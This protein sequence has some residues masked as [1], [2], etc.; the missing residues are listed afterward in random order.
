MDWI[1]YHH[2]YYFWIIATEGGVTAASKKIRLSQSTLSAQLKQ[3]EDSLG[4]PLFDRKYR[5]LV[6]TES[7]RLALD[8]ASN[9]FKMGQEMHDLIRNRLV[10][11]KKQIVRIGALSSLSKNLQFDFISPCIDDPDIRVIV[12]E[13][14]L[15]ELTAKLE[16]FELDLVISNMPVRSDEKNHIYNHRL[17]SIPVCAVG[18][19][20]FKHLRSGFPKSLSKVRLFVPNYQSRVRSE[21]ELYLHQRGIEPEIQAEV[22]DMALLR[23]LAL[24]GKGLSIVPQIVVKTELKSKQLIVIHRFKEVS[25][26]FFALVPK[27]QKPYPAVTNLIEVFSQRLQREF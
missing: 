24:S 12:L 17:G 10:S 3:L 18:N 16:N 6:L 8:Y 15:N 27:R 26:V 2:L 13:G 1:N 20:S 14:N 5:N 4:Q 21:F 25:E 11:K 9:I 22:E 7:G 19:P 23:I